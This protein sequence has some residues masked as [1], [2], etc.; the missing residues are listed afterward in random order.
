MGPPFLCG[1]IVFQYEFLC[2]AINLPDD[3]P[4]FM[5]AGSKGYLNF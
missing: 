5:L 2:L 3:F 4:A 1:N